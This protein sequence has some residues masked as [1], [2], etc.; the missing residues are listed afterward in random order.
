M[1]RAL[2]SSALL[3]LL[4]GPA[5]AEVAPVTAQEPARVVR[6]GLACTLRACRPERGSPM[7]HAVGFAVVSLAAAWLAHGRGSTRS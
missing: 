2:A 6:T 7:V 4:S 3:L 1:C 5:A